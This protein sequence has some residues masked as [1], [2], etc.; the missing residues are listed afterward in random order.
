MLGSL[1]GSPSFSC[2]VSSVANL[3]VCSSAPSLKG[4]PCEVTPFPECGKIF[5]LL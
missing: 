2:T 3:S 5:N 4:Q 1:G